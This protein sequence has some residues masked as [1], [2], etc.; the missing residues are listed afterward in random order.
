MGS[1]GMQQR[2]EE[3]KTRPRSYSQVSQWYRCGHQFYL[4][5][6]KRASEIQAAWFAHGLAVHYAAE[7][8]ETSGRT[9]PLEEVHRHF[10]EKYTREIARAR[11]VEP[12]ERQWFSSGPYAGIED[13]HRRHII[14]LNQVTAYV[15]YYQAHPDEVPWPGADS[16]ETEFAL[17]LGGVK[18]V[19]FIDL[20][21]D[22]PRKGVVVRDTKTGQKPTEHTQLELYAL[23]VNTL[24]GAECSWGDY[25]LAKTGRTS[26]AL[27]LAPDA[28]RLTEWVGAM[29]EGVKREEFVPNPGQACARCPV[30][31][32]CA[33]A[34]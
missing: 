14:G 17:E 25:W 11:A 16:I 13:I 10:D 24:H 20:V 21:V 22:H 33:Y 34:M 1:D 26:R 15:D 29:D 18:V 7:Q 5:R 4:S 8:W 3:Y 28:S 31:R 32:H 9:L 12:D 2:I 6:I 23:A 19:G 30:R 27:P